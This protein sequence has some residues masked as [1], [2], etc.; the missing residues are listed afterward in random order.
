MLEQVSCIQ[1]SQ[2]YWNNSRS[3]LALGP[4]SLNVYGRYLICMNLMLA[5]MRAEEWRIVAAIT[6]YYRPSPKVVN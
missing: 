6:I 2:T 5:H 4:P 1:H 3:K